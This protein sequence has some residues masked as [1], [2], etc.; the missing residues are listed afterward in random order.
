MAD[1]DWERGLAPCDGEE[2]SREAEEVL[3]LTESYLKDAAEVEVDEDTAFERALTDRIERV[4]NEVAEQ[5]GVDFAYWRLRVTL[6]RLTHGIAPFGPHMTLVD[7][8]DGYCNFC[9]H[10]TYYYDRRLNAHICAD[11]FGR[12]QRG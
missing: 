2:I 10:E 11:C 7:T 1:N 3:R 5:H 12:T 4:V 9:G 8:H 6:Q